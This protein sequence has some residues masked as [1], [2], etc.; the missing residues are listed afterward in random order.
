MIRPERYYYDCFKSQ[1]KINSLLSDQQEEVLKL[2]ASG[3]TN[4]EI[5]T[6]LGIATSTVTCHLSKPCRPRGIYQR[7]GVFSRTE[8]VKRAI[9]LGILDANEFVTDEEIERCRS[10]E[11]P[12]HVDVLKALSSPLLSFHL[13]TEVAIAKKTGI[14]HYM[15]KRYL[16]QIYEKLG[17]DGKHGQI[18]ST[19]AVVIFIAAR[20]KTIFPSH[21]RLREP[22]GVGD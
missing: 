16:H 9:T 7:L 18:K 3:L 2:V 10:F 19:R 20:Q 14:S 12:R 13:L 5:G 21:E 8:A 11:N 22:N 15:V 1:E 6:E 4:D 17:I